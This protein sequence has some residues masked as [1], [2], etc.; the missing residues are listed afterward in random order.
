MATSASA[1]QWAFEMWHTGKVILDTGDT[2]RG[3]IKYDLQ[4][5]IIQLNASSRLESYT[6]RKVLLFEI[7]D[8]TVRRYRTFYSLP[9]SHAGQYK[10]PVF[11][12][13]L[14]EGK[15]TVLTRESLEYR[16]T[17]SPYYFYGN[18]TRLVLVNKYYIL[19]ENGNIEEF[20][21]KKND[22]FEFMPGKAEEVERFAKKNRLKFDDKYDLSRII[23]YYNSLFGKS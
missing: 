11:F 9:Y 12:E 21:G 17:S 15:L 14:Q 8:E 20:R 22:W 2:L 23:E 16:T 10:A 6:A 13:L 4:N 5:D 19:K 1:Q 7:F 18:Y 3:L